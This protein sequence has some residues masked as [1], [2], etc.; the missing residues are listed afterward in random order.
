MLTKTIIKPNTYFD[1]VTLMRIS[2]QLA[3]MEGV[4]DILVGMGTDLNKESLA[5]VDLLTGEA[6]AAS[7][8]DLL[9]GVRVTGEEVLERV[10]QKIDELLS[11]RRDSTADGSEGAPK[12]QLRSIARACQSQPGYNLALISVPG[13][14]AAREAREALH[15]GMHVFL[16]SDN[17]SVEDEI[18]LKKKAT[19][20]GLLM[21]GPD[22]GTAII[23]GVPLGFANRVRRG[24]IGIVG[25]SGTGI[26]QV[27]TLIDGL[28]KG[29]S[30]AIGTGGRDLSARVGGMT[31]L[32]AL[33]ALAAD[34]QT[35]V[36]VL[37]SKPPAPEVAAKVLDR[38][39]DTGKPVVLCLL[40]AGT[41][42]V[43]GKGIIQCRNLEET[44]LQAV[45]LVRGGQPVILPE[46][47]GDRPAQEFLARR[48]PNQKY[49]RA[50]YGGGTLCDEAMTVF[51]DAGIPIFSN[52]PL[53]PEENLANVE[54]SQGHTFLD[55]G[56]DY[57]TRGRPH[58]MLEPSLRIPRLLQEAAD[59]EVAIILLDV[60]L[61]HG[62]HSDPA[63]VTAR[64]IQQARQRAATAGRQLF[65]ITALIGTAADPQG[66]EQQ[67]RLLEE[68]GVAVFT[69]NVRAAR[70]AASLAQEIAAPERM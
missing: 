25:A 22:C 9:I 56:E 7:P 44:A 20:K 2:G 1:S 29:I 63:G 62:S 24:G 14:Y 70:V 51:R 57:F 39:A 59:P 27:T 37:I 61:G 23:N 40:G 35:K 31:T 54:R 45:S 55:M 46:E 13:I 52:V 16:F 64:G 41:M 66:L 47:G 3:E 58:P 65:F 53:T 28:G 68:A 17:V 10:F 26:Q 67:R 42:P 15:Q 69:S 11:Q 34:E 60:I 12:E 48:K 38:A 33:D 43:E 50:L 4:Q 6:G 19:A 49:V 5:R 30:Q 36:I 32:A 8:N 21:M 18:D